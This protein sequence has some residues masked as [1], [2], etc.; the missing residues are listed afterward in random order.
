[1]CVAITDTRSLSIAF[2]WYS[3]FTADN[4]SAWVEQRPDKYQASFIAD[5]GGQMLQSACLNKKTAT[6]LHLL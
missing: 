5:D 2:A 4:L 1:M 6:M 3:V